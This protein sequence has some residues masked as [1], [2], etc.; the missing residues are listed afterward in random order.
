MMKAILT[1][2]EKNSAGFNL[3]EWLR[4]QGFDLSDNIKSEINEQGDYHF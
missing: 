3:I 1:K 2:I 4:K